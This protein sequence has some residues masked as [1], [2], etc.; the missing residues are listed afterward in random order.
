MFRVTLKQ[1]NRK[2]AM[3][4]VLKKSIFCVLVFLIACS[5]RPWAA[6]AQE[7]SVPATDSVAKETPSEDGFASQI[8]KFT[9]RKVGDQKV[10]LKY[11]L[12]KGDVI[13]WQHDHRTA[14][15]TRFGG[16]S[17]KTATRARPEYQW[18]VQNVDSRG[19]MR[20]DIEM[21]RI[22]VLEQQGEADP[23]FYD[24]EKHDEAPDSCQPYQERLGRVCSTYSISPDGVVVNAKS[25]YRKVKLGGVGDNPVIAFPKGPIGVGH[26]WDM[27]M[28][29]RGKDEH[30]GF[31]QVQLRIRFV[32]EKIVDGKA[33]ITFFTETLTPQLDETVRS[34]IVTHMTRGFI[35]FD[36]AKGMLTH[37]E[38]RW[39]ERVIGYQGPES[40][41]HYT[42]FRTETLKPAKVAKKVDKPAVK[43]ANKQPETPQQTHTLLKPMKK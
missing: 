21:Q 19:N 2:E 23:I 6:I 29:V 32:L 24:S 25:N 8:E 14:V 26:K 5:I 33:H 31:Q 37:R 10:V 18:T 40:Y 27:N 4:N 22:K 17:E 43:V 28:S 20:F 13:H 42:A 9:K 1:T 7:E 41:M 38:T 39:D 15:E 30:G 11:K 16:A 3:V 34:Q 35:V 12:N 36:I